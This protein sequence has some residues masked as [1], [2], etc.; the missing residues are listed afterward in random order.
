MEKF[1]D[2]VYF[3]CYEIPLG[4]Y[5]GWLKSSQ[6]YQ[7]TLMEY[8]QML[9]IHNTTIGRNIV[10]NNVRLQWTNEHTSL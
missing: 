4:I 5:E 9:Y 7:D 6:A 10:N 2:S 1:I 8:D 3:Q